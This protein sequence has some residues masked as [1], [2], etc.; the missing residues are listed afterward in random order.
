MCAVAFVIACAF[1]H[2]TASAQTNDLLVSPATGAAGSRFQVVATGGWLP[3]ESV[4]IDVA[5]SD[6][7]PAV[8]APQQFYHQGD[9]AVLRDGTWSFPLVVN[10]AL[11]AFPLYRPGFIVVRAQ[12]ASKSALG[13]FVYTVEGREPAGA[14]PL[15]SLGA[16]MP[17]GD[18]PLVIAAALLALGIGALTLLAG[19]RRFSH[20]VPGRTSAELKLRGYVARRS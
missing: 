11:F 5:F 19:A 12:S 18:S 10:K 6:V 8:A 20:G 1:F 15:A 4:S 16:G 14:P 9:I 13:T 3:G 2:G 17:R 7:E